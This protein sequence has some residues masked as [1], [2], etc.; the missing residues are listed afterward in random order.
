M[1]F[2]VSDKNKLGSYL[3][4]GIVLDVVLMHNPVGLNWY[5]RTRTPTVE[6]QEL[7]GATK[8][9]TSFDLGIFTSNFPLP[10]FCSSVDTVTV[11][12]LVMR[13]IEKVTNLILR[14]S[15]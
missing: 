2:Q 3:I 8:A 15:Y 1:K 6:S 9:V 10:C 4:T 12:V 14:L 11:P 13:F 7:F 5:L